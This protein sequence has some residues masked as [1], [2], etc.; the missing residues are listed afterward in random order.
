MHSCTLRWPWLVMYLLEY[1]YCT[2]QWGI[3]VTC[4]EA[5]PIRY[6]AMFFTLGSLMQYSTKQ[7]RG[8]TT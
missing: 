1:L 2:V 5:G 7:M 3:P 6:R 8:M 4:F